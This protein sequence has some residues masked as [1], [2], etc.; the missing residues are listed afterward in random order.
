[1]NLAEFI[2]KIESFNAN[3]GIPVLKRAYEFSAQAHKG[4]YRESGDPYV[5]HCLEVA[6]I[7]AE[8]HMDSATI[9]AGLM[10]DVVEET[11]VTI[12]Q[13]RQE[14]GEE[15]A[16]LVDGVT[17]ISGV[18]FESTE[19]KQVDYY[20][21]MLLSMAKDIRVIITKLADRLHNMRTLEALDEKRRKRIS[22][23]TLDVYA[24]L[25]HRF[26]MS[27]I[28]DELEDLCLKHLHF[29]AY[30]EIAQKLDLTREEMEQYIH[31]V[32]LPLERELKEN[33]IKAEIS[34]RAKHF[35]SIYRK[36]VSRSKPFDEIDDLIAI[37]VIVNSD[38]ECYQTLGIVHNLWTPVAERFD[39]Y[40]ATPKSNMY[41]SLH[42]TVVGPLGKMVE[43][44]IR[45]FRMHRTAEY[46][47][48][49]HWLYKEGRKEPDESD[50][51][52]IWLREVLEWQK[53]LTNPS[54]FLEYL[55][56]DLFDDDIFVFTPR[57]DLK[58]L[59]K[60]STPLDFAYAVHSDVGN[61]CMGARVDGKMVPLNTL[62]KSGDR[63]E[64]LTSP[65]QTP[66]QDWLKIV[67]TSRARSKIRRWFKQKGYE[68]SRKLGQEILEKELKKNN[69]KMLSE[70]EM[71]DLAA[72]LN[73]SDVESLYAAVG[74]G[75][76]SIKQVLTKLLPREEEKVPIVR[77]VLEK[78]RGRTGINIQGLGNLMFRF[79]QCCQPLPGEEI[80]GFITKGRGVSIHRSDCPN[81]LQMM[82]E[83]DRRVDV[84]WDVRKDQSFLV[85]LEVML[86]DR[87]GLL[88][89]ITEAIADADTN[90]RGAEIKPSE[91]PTHGTLL[92]EVKNL[93]H[94]NRAIKKIRRVKGVIMVQRAK[95]MEE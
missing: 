48:A 7:L 39:D 19:E 47:V 87:K 3:V 82:V 58:Q 5:E 13:I 56:I 11:D 54:E 43:I 81:A 29:G 75:D 93:R 88:H 21:K 74:S 55:K 84:Q 44:Q 28:K 86:E 14:F 18:E 26:G 90:I 85:K 37:R 68:D 41:R 42:T 73:F 92:I 23:E 57:G 33:G 72:G 15:I 32:T 50:K 53:D 70:Q 69:I 79:A 30:Q 35:Y 61:R 4:Q 17:H 1:M 25:A 94:L 8:Q 52:M 83:N 38:A 78:A 9:A 95:G 76:T 40:I 60:G 71:D 46:G 2:I 34:G 20:R 31:R 59:S 51:Q 91:P 22:Q 27:R 10:H 16:E 80:V 64:I 12:D 45:T 67:K 24:P 6:F 63:V 65:H 62:L 49:A 89:D 36:M 66:S 77:R